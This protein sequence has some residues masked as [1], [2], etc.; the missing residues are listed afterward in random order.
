MLSFSYAHFRN[1]VFFSKECPY[2]V[3]AFRGHARQYLKEMESIHPSCIT[4]IIHS[5]ET[6]EMFRESQKIVEQPEKPKKTLGKC[7]K[8]GYMSSHQI[9]MACEL[10]AKLKVPECV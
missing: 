5:A 4:D 3:G 1:L 2:A 8:C 6:L 7:I 10:L 9:C